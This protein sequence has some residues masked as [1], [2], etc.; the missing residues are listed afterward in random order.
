MEQ[1]NYLAFG[2]CLWNITFEHVY[3]K[4][5]EIYKIDYQFHIAH[6]WITLVVE[7]FYNLSLLPLHP[8][9]TRAL[10]TPPQ[11]TF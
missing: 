8:L 11:T 3:I 7:Y 1:K 6:I 9:L 4:T 10:L 5:V 2:Y